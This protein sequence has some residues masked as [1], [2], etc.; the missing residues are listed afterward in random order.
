[1]HRTFRA[2]LAVVAL[3]ALAVVLPSSTAREGKRSRA[4][5]MSD[6]S[7][8]HSFARSQA[9]LMAGLAGVFF[10]LMAVFLSQVLAERNKELQ[11]LQQQ[12]NSEEHAEQQVKHSLAELKAQLDA[13]KANLDS[14]DA[15]LD[16]ELDEQ[17]LLLKVNLD[18]SGRIFEYAPG[19]D[20]LDCRN[21]DAAV[22]VLRKAIQTV[23]ANIY[24]Q[25]P[26]FEH[27]RIQIVH[28]IVLE[29]HTDNAPIADD[30]FAPKSC[31]G[32]EA[33]RTEDARAYGREFGANVALSGRRAA[34]IVR[35]VT[36]SK[37]ATEEDRKCVEKH[38]LISGR[39]PVEPAQ[40]GGRT[41]T[42]LS[43]WRD[44]AITEADKRKNRRVIL[45]IEGRQDIKRLASELAQSL[46]KERGQ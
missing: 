25:S 34:N 20:Q 15:R 17:R 33:E 39:G 16:V 26:G 21:A 44:K 29:G 8:E 4:A 46:G 22:E 3:M 1:M 7:P 18:E 40:V 41:A 6:E 2:G 9:D 42:E 24:V 28:R 10:V 36:E 45:F 12:D 38:F 32:T 27:D 23:C 43:S 11:R 14:K 19:A 31:P 35:L 37:G 30:R 5:S 13:L